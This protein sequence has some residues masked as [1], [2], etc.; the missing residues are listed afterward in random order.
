MKL[1]L[2]P[3]FLVTNGW[4]SAYHNGATAIRALFNKLPLL[5]IEAFCLPHDIYSF[6]EF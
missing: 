4:A 2:W 3:Q 5:D 1:G 6:Y